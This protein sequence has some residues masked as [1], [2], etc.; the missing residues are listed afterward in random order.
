M[1]N[2]A[3]KQKEIRERSNTLRAK[4]K[5]DD[6]E[7]KYIDGNEQLEIK[8]IIKESFG[9]I[10]MDNEMLLAQT[11]CASRI[12]ELREKKVDFF[13][14]DEV[15]PQI[16]RLFPSESRKIIQSPILALSDPENSSLNE[17]P[18]TEL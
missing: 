1:L 2:S 12:N 7:S 6:E 17:H 13:P 18:D 14:G 16:K 15:C 4:H 5:Q 3:E 10:K 8:E 11:E 9:G